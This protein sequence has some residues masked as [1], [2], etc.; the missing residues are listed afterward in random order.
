M[1][2]GFEDGFNCAGADEGD[3]LN[4]TIASSGGQFEGERLD[5]S[6]IVGRAVGQG[7][8]EHAIEIEFQI[9]VIGGERVVKRDARDLES[10]RAR[11]GETSDS[12]DFAGTNLGVASLKT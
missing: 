6:A 5:V 12:A 10:L 3:A 11:T 7:A 2:R 8:G 9:D 4:K 1:Q